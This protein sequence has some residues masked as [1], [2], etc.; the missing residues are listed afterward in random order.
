[1]S[2]LLLVII[3]ALPPLAVG[4]G[5]EQNAKWSKQCIPLWDRPLPSHVTPDRTLSFLFCTTWI[6]ATSA[7]YHGCWL[8]NAVVHAME[9][10]QTWWTVFHKHFLLVWSESLK[11]SS[12]VLKHLWPGSFQAVE[13]WR[14]LQIFIQ[15]LK[16][17]IRLHVILHTNL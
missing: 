10:T 7:L 16:H 2:L 14:N 1:M 17:L 9:L 12:S 6:T 13:I 8:L 4:E 5:G 11:P 3:L 15:S